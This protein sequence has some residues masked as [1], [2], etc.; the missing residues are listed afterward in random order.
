MKK[1][2]TSLG[3]ATLLLSMPQLVSADEDD[4]KKEMQKLEKEDRKHQEEMAREKRKYQEEMER[5][6]KKR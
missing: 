5:E 6:R 2:L 4:Y 1:L 3:L